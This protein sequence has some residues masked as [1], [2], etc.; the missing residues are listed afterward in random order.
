MRALTV[1]PGEADSLA[2]REV[3]DPRP[4]SDE[5]LVR[6]LALGICGTDREIAGGEY[7]SAPPGRE[8]LV[9]G[10]ESLGRVERA[11]E[12]SGFAVGDLVVGMVRRPDP[13]P[14]EACAHG[15]FDMC[16][17]GRYTERGIKDLDGYGSEMWCVP[18][19]Y[20]VL[21]PKELERT[22]VLTEPASVVAKAWAQVDAIGSRSYFVPRRALVTGAGPI[23]LLAALIAAQRGLDVH[24][25]DIVA[26]GRKPD[27]VRALGATYHH[28][29]PG[30]LCR[31]LDPDV[32]IEATGVGHVVFDVIAGTSP[33]GIVCLTGVSPR[34]RTLTID[35][36]TLNRT[37]VLDNEVVVG[38]VN[39]A[40]AHYTQAV[41]TLS[42]ADPTW[43]ES[44]ITR[45]I[46]LDDLPKSFPPTHDD[47]KAVIALD[48]TQ[49]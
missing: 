20:A 34:G 41:T 48:D 8:Y 27:L 49:L 3:D 9:L 17:N 39:A 12:G 24:V 5:L 30:D 18:V 1:V 10:H 23:G 2:V 7:G 32:V 11:P 6:G 31:D 46:P 19:D 4:D 15:R 28:T 29:D 47:V 13:V 22:G 42:T 25:L 44:L 16:R 26:A 45:R 43:L 35:A 14:C 33:N 36:N 40:P 38:S 37:L 21:L